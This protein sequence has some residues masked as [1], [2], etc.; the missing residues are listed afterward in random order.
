MTGTALL[1]MSPDHVRRSLADNLRERRVIVETAGSA[2]DA[3]GKDIL[4]DA[5]VVV[6]DLTMAGDG[7]AL[8]A[9]M[10][11]AARGGL[12][13]LGDPAGHTLASEA[14]RAGADDFVPHPPSPDELAAR[15]RALIR[16][17]REYC[18]SAARIELGDVLVDCERH[19][20]WVRGE[21]VALT[22]KEFELLRE[23]ADNAGGLVAREELLR[24][25][26]GFDES[27][28]SRT[29][30]VHIGRLRKKIESDPSRPSLI[31]TVPRVGYRMAA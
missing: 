9:R 1:V 14:L 26:W 2:D 21:S 15:V 20:V 31:V 6:F 10:R 28:A 18:S 17:L 24:E 12:I 13:A 3:R 4:G 7:A 8:C 29:L 5:D 11:S 23:L 19:Q 30:D 25:V 22:P 16:R 27:I